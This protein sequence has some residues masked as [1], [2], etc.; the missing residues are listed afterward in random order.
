MKKKGFTLVELLAVIVILAIITLIAVPT[1]LG[2][3]QKTKRQAAASSA[4]GYVDAVEKYQAISTLKGERSLAVGIY[5]VAT[6]TTV[7]EYKYEKINDLISFKGSK[8]TVGT[9]G[10]T[11]NGTVGTAT[12][13]INNYTV[14]YSNSKAEV[15]SNDCE[16]I[17]YLVEY[18]ISSE[19]WASSKT[20]TI[21]YPEVEYN[22]YMLKLES[23]KATLNGTE[24]TI[25]EEVQVDSREV[26]VE[27]LENSKITA[28]MVKDNRKVFERSYEETKIDNVELGSIDI[29]LNSVPLMT[30]SKVINS[31]TLELI[32]DEQNGTTAYYSIDGGATWIKYTE[33]VNADIDKAQA[34]LVRDE[35][36]REGEIVEVSANIG[37]SITSEA[38]DGDFETA[39]IYH[40]GYNN[41]NTTD[42]TTWNKYM[43]VDNSA[44]ETL[45]TVKW[46]CWDF[47]GYAAYFDF[48]DVDGNVLASH[49]ISGGNTST[50][51]FY[52]PVNTYRINYY[53]N[54]VSDAY[55]SINSK[56]YEIKVQNDI[57]ETLELNSS[58]INKVVLAKL[59]N[60]NI[61][62]KIDNSDYQ[63]YT[64]SIPAIANQLLYIKA[65][66]VYTGEVQNFEYAVQDKMAKYNEIFDND[67]STKYMPSLSERDDTIYIKIAD[68]MKGKKVR[69]KWRDNNS[70]GVI[71]HLFMD[72]VY[73]EISEKVQ[74]SNL[75]TVD[76]IYDI[77]ENA[78]YL[79]FYIDYSCDIYEIDPVLE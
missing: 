59:G 35:S 53:M 36:K 17:G 65:T 2:I 67:D 21:L 6:S 42:K 25:N 41:I 54:K 61:E 7:N 26:A 18:N 33:I 63:N 8:P 13:C 23:G 68:E 75:T 12:L 79:Y 1:I 70:G 77:P 22:T 57:Y 60:L 10:I 27:L 19:E 37:N 4:L 30:S 72:N 47:T 16:D 48:E 49:S 11:Q 55:Y 39:M 74:L 52:V 45:L 28:W 29:S 44:W 32:Y 15:I 5:N 38:Y 62:Y 34:K 51:Y 43:L 40:A 14:E 69:I 24:M 3:I 78:E 9:V 66:N 73:T 64:G 20:L 50:E 46:Y 31:S 58:G 56:L 71:Y 76:Q